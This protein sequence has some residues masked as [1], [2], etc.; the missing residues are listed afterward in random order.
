M[1]NKCLEQTHYTTEH[2]Q[3]NAFLLLKR[4]GWTSPRYPCI[5]YFDQRPHTLLLTARKDAPQTLEHGFDPQR[6][7]NVPIQLSVHD[8]LSPF[9]PAILGFIIVRTIMTLLDEHSEHRVIHNLLSYV[10]RVTSRICISSSR[11]AASRASIGFSY[12]RFLDRDDLIF[13]GLTDRVCCCNTKNLPASSRR[14]VIAS[15]WC[16]DLVSMGGVLPLPTS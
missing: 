15:I 8:Q 9:T 12:T 7:T 2:P 11:R 3:P 14:G 4:T 13:L 10:S 6:R 5:L 16:N 1:R